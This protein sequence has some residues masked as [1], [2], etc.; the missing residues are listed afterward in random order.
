MKLNFSLRGSDLTSKFQL[1][2]TRRA[3][4]IAIRKVIWSPSV[5]PLKNR[6]PR[7]GDR[8]RL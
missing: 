2:Q 7:G 1:V 8:S 4:V 6:G 3:L 5:L